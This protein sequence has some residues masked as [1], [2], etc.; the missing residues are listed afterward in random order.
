MDECVCGSVQLYWRRRRVCVLLFGARSAASTL[1]W[2]GLDCDA[3][4]F[5]LA[6]LERSGGGAACL[7]HALRRIQKVLFC[8]R[9]IIAVEKQERS[10]IANTK[11]IHIYHRDAQCQ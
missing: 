3:T 2:W 1:A 5:C 7:N 10:D 6:V 4:M 11:P 8:G 9:T